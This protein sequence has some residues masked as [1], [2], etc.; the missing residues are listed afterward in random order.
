ME[1][2][3]LLLTIKRMGINGEGIAYYKRKAVFIPYAIPGEIV[4][5]KITQ[6]KDNYAYGEVTHYKKMSEYR[7]KPRCEYYGRC[8]GC[9]LQHMAYPFQLEQKQN[10]VIE[11]CHNISF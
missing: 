4:E 1:N 8:G 5:A 2:Q 9:Q 10:I 3:K 11:Y 6:Q 7:V